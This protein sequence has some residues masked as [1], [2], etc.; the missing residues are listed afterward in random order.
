VSR[1]VRIGIALLLTVL[2]AGS[3]YGANALVAN[4]AEAPEAP[5][6]LAETPALANTAAPAAAAGRPPIARALS[7]KQYI[8][9]IMSR[10]LFDVAVID[11]WATR[12]EVTPGGKPVEADIKAHLLAVMVATPAEFS[13]A[14]ISEESS[15]D[16]PGSYSIGDTFHDR[17]VVEI[18]NDRVGLQKEGESIEYL[19][20]EGGELPTSIASDESP[21]EESTGEVEPL[22]ENKFAVSKDLFDKNINDLEGISRMGRALLHRG[23]DGEFDGY[24]L[25]AIRRDTLADQL[26]I[27]N[28]D[29]IHSVNGQPLNSVQSAMNAYNTMRTESSFCFEISRRGSPTELCY[30]VR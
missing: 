18:G 2:A 7:E 30:E 9:G 20:L 10:N 3:A 16:L 27:K 8:D 22:G 12:V 21:S 11:E 15:P 6:E 24:R 14:L 19:L 26:G 4:L 29:I 25:S 5:P 23:P 1:N 28:G 13:S 17:K